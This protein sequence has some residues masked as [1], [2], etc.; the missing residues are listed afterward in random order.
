MLKKRILILFLTAAL[1]FVFDS[2]YAD[3]QKASTLQEFAAAVEKH[4]GRLETSFSI[5]CTWALTEE[6]KKTSPVGKGIIQLSE[7]MMRAGCDFYTVTWYDDHVRLSGIGYYA[8]WKILY[9]WQ[10]GT[11]SMLSSREAETLEKALILVAGASGSDL[12][13][14]RYIYDTL[15]AAVTY[16]Q[17]EDGSGDKDCAIGTLLNGRADCDGYSDAMMLCCGLAGISCRYIHGD[18]TVP[19]KPGSEDGTH[20]WNLVHIGGSWLICDLTWGDDDQA[21]PNYLYFN[22]GRR[23]ASVTYYWNADTQFGEIASMADF[24]TQLMPD[25]QPV[26]VRTQED[27]YLAARKTATAGLRHLSLYCP[28]E[29]LWQTDPVTFRSMLDY[30][31]MNRY[32][33]SSSG[34][35]YAISNITLPEG[36]FCFCDSREEILTAIGEYADTGIR[37]FTLYFLPDLAEQLLTERSNPLLQV[38]SLSRLASPDHYEYSIISSCAILTDVSYIAPLPSC[39]SAEEISSLLRQELPA[40]PSSLTFLLGDGLSFESVREELSTTALSL[41]VSTLSHLL[42]GSRITLSPEYYDNYCI[43]DSEAEVL[44]LMAA[45][46]NSGGNELRVYCSGEL[47]ASLCENNGQ[48]FFNLLQQAGFQGYQVYH[49]DEIC[50]IMANSLY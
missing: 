33:Y 14:E 27:V 28:E 31:G 5:S 32:S 21:E 38:F 34:R 13:K 40:R 22:L 12:E 3:T 7:I 41:G 26:V 16:D 39:R 1:L 10:T 50:M 24:S 44:S 42:T 23:D 49:S 6:L 35:M 37:S 17:A 2:V 43:A 29:V 18:S 47:Y 25:Q 46:L 11:T 9:C 8:G 36:N 30:C 15:C 45:T 48:R 20:M 19:S 4:T